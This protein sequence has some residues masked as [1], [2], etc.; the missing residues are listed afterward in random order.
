MRTT[1]ILC[2]SIAVLAVFGAWLHAQPSK[3]Y[4]AVQLSMD[5]DD[6]ALLAPWLDLEAIRSNIKSREAAR[7]Q[8]GMPPPGQGGPGGLLGLL[9][10]VLADSVI[11]ALVQGVTTPEGV[12]AMLRA[13]AA[14]AP[15]VP[16]KTPSTPSE[17]LFGR[18]STELVGFDRYVVSAQLK[19]NAVLK[20][21]FARQGTQWK[22]SD[23][24]VSKAAGDS[25]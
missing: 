6:P 14:A 5:R 25:L 24:D 18:A 2:V 16:G 21:V 7:L 13:A 10:Q 12:L 19:G 15:D 4:Q 9:G 11:G 20:L 17:R 23:I 8:G 22:L 3:A 1:I